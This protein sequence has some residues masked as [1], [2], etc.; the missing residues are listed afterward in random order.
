[1]VIADRNMAVAIATNLLSNAVTYSPPGGLVDCAVRNIGSFIELSISNTNGSLTPDDLRHMAQPF[2]RKD[3]SRSDPSHSGL[4]LALVS[5]YA[6]VQG[7]EFEVLL[8]PENLFR[9]TVRFPIAG[10]ERGAP[11]LPGATMSAARPRQS[12]RS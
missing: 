9:A 4:G 10:I 5:A 11:A 7:A 6:I 3:T 1:V 8:T 12:D 2:W